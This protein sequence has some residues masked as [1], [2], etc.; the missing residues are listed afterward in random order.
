MGDMIFFSFS[1]LIAF[2]VF[3]TCPC[4]RCPCP[5]CPC[6][7]DNTIITQFRSRTQYGKYQPKMI[8]PCDWPF[9]TKTIMFVHRSLENQFL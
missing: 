8:R 5:C 7:P 1:A 6:F 3:F 9:E 2:V 4:T